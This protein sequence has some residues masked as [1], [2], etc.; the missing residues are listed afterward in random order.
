MMSGG[1]GAASALPSGRGARSNGRRTADEEDAPYL[2]LQ[3][4]QDLPFRGVGAGLGAETAA[5]RNG[6][7][8]W[9]SQP[10]HSDGKKHGDGASGG[11]PRQMSIS[12]EADDSASFLAPP[13]GLAAGLQNLTYGTGKR[14]VDQW[15]YEGKQWDLFIS[16]VLFLLLSLFRF[17]V[18]C[19]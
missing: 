12:I 1:A 18:V 15:L 17:I 4:T 19:P 2:P 5:E 6:P 16:D 9:E 14:A 7:S 10:L 13:T 11:R 8:S 3:P